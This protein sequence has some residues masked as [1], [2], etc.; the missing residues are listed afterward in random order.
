MDD[1]VQ[2]ALASDRNVDITTIG[3]QSGQPRRIEIWHHLVDGAVYITGLPGKRSWYANVVANPDMTFH[4]KESVQ[5]D[6][7]ARAVA[8]TDEAARREIFARMKAAEQRLGH[9]DV[10]RWVAESPLIRIDFQPQ[11]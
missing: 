3:R 7:P 4:L 9:L 6:F 11:G 5:R 2:Q 10:E 1:A 8:I